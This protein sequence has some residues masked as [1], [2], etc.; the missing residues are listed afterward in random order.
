MSKK[1]VRTIYQ[2]LVDKCERN[3]RKAL[4]IVKKIEPIVV[5]LDNPRK[6]T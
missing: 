2:K 5:F 1:K 4:K 3:T 6:R